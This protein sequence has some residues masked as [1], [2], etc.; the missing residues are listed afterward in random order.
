M[1]AA[2]VAINIGGTTITIPAPAGYVPVTKDMK[3]LDQT[4]EALVAPQNVRLVSFIPAEGLAAVQAGGMP[5]LRRTLS[6]QTNRKTVDL[7]LTTHDFGE[8]KDVVM[9]QN[10]DL[11]KT[12]EKEVAGLTQKL[13]QNIED[14]FH[15][16]LALSIGGMVPFPP[17]EQSERSLSYSM[18]VNYEVKGAQGQPAKAAGYVTTTFLHAKAKF[19]FLYVNG[20]ANDLEWSRATAKSW[21]AAILAANPSDAA[22]AAREARTRGFDFAQLWRAVLIGGC[23]GGAIGLLRFLARKKQG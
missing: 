2:D 4:L 18:L 16:N 5:S 15:T 17:H 9:K 22:T 6:V 20:D 8:L 23:V 1:F 21:A 19:F 12:A 3:L 10:A 13:N 7:E 14:Q 11:V